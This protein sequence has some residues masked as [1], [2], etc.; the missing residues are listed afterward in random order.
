MLSLKRSIGAL[1][2]VAMT[3]LPAAA[4]GGQGRGGQM[5]QRMREMLFEGITL[6]A[7]QQA[8]VD[9]IQKAIQEER[10]EM[11][12]NGGGDRDA[13]MAAMQASQKKEMDAIRAVLT[14]EQMPTFD[15]NVEKL[16]QMRR[17]RGPGGGGGRPPRG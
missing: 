7:V 2:L 10:M 3:A 4:Q 8:S 12:Q 1:L 15:A 17:R 13:M 9:S 5:Q 6:T 14:A 11:R 16:Q